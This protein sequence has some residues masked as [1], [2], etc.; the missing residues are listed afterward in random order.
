MADYTRVARVAAYLAAID[1]LSLP[2]ANDN[3]PPAGDLIYVA[4]SAATPGGY[5]IR[6]FEWPS[7]G[8]FVRCAEVIV[9]AFIIL[10][11]L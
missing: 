10:F 3:E 7:F 8:W 11:F 9:A 1:T 5:V 2:A 6:R 4:P